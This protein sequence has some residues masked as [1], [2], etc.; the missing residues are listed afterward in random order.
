MGCGV[1]V[2]TSGRTISV[3][4]LVSCA[5]VCLSVVVFL[6]FSEQEPATDVRVSFGGGGEGHVRELMSQVAGGVQV[7]A[8]KNTS[9]IATRLPSRF[10]IDFCREKRCTSSSYILPTSSEH[11][12]TKRV[13]PTE[14]IVSF[15]VDSFTCILTVTL[16]R[17]PPPC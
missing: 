11:H 8:K 5:M 9:R 13:S 2:A 4:I 17:L 14:D 12:A 6:F 10:Y 1:T 3:S 15:V 7:S 16:L